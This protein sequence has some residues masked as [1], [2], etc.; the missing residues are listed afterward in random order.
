MRL[1]RKGKIGVAAIIL[2]AAVL[3][4]LGVAWRSTFPLTEGAARKS[5]VSKK[6]VRYPNWRDVTIPV[7]GNVTT[8][9][10]TPMSIRGR[11]NKG[12]RWVMWRLR[13][14]AYDD[15]NKYDPNP[16][17]AQ[18]RDLNPYGWFSYIKEDEIGGFS[19]AFDTPVEQLGE[20]YL[21]HVQTL[22]TT[23]THS[24]VTR[25][26]DSGPEGLGKV[27]AWETKVPLETTTQVAPGVSIWGELY[28]KWRPY[29]LMSW[30]LSADDEVALN[31]CTSDLEADSLLAEVSNRY[32]IHTE[33]LSEDGGKYF[34]VKVWDFGKNALMTDE[35]RKEQEKERMNRLPPEATMTVGLNEP[36]QVSF[37]GSK[38]V[39]HFERTS[40]GGTSIKAVWGDQQI[41]LS[42]SYMQADTCKIKVY[43]IDQD[44][45][46]LHLRR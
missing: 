21:L 43:Y 37:N 46:L 26:Y 14:Y 9:T 42:P 27:K 45:L 38:A 36:K 17:L 35:E 2:L 8:I 25:I 30:A 13:A 28:G 4:T 23:E 10:G 7:S 24:F 3:T 12:G 19:T 22:T 5:E 1:S 11:M 15:S 18:G 44:Q 6:A 20:R 16:N 32:L 33:R 39:V 29:E 40:G 41:R 34:V 31:N